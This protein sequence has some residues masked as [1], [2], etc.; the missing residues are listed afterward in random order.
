[1]LR[2]KLIWSCKAL[3]FPSP[4]EF[5]IGKK[6]FVDRTVEKIKRGKFGKGVGDGCYGLQH[7]VR[8][9]VE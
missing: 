7:L 6:R 3:K 8:I 2:R 1:M 5:L 9:V 4:I